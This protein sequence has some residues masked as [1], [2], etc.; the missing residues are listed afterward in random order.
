MINL[1]EVGATIDLNTKN[2]E[3][4]IKN[5]LGDAGKLDKAILGIESASKL[6]L[7]SIGAFTAGIVALGVSVG[8]I[9]LEYNKEIE[10]VTTDFEVM[11]GSVEDGVN[12][13]E[14]L[15][16]MASS[17]PFE[18]PQL[19]QN[20]K[21]LLAFNIASDDTGRILRQL[22]DISLG[23]AEKLD[24]LTR[25]YGKMNASQ[26]VSLED[27]NIMIDA[28]FNPLLLVAEKTGETMTELYDRISKGKVSVNEI[29]QAFD[30][31]TGVGGQFYQ[32][33]E[34]ASK[35][36]QGL[37]STLQDNSN[38][39]FGSLVEPISEVLK[40]D[41]L[42]ALIDGIAELQQYLEDNP[43]A[44]ED[45]AKGLKDLSTEGIEIVLDGVKWF[46]D[47][48][49]DLGT[50][51]I[52][53]ASNIG[54]VATSLKLIVGILSGNIVGAVIGGVGLLGSLVVK[55]GN[56]FNST[57]E[58]AEEFNKKIEFALENEKKFME[59]NNANL[60]TPYKQ[61]VID[62]YDKYFINT[63]KEKKVLK[64]TND[65]ESAINEKLAIKLYAKNQEKNEQLLEMQRMLELKKAKAKE[66]IQTA[67]LVEK[68]KELKEV[69]D[70][71]KE[72]PNIKLPTLQETE[73]KI[74]IP[75]VDALINNLFTDIPQIDLSYIF[76]DIENIADKTT[77]EQIEADKNAKRLQWEGQ[78]RW[79]EL[80]NFL[81]DKNEETAD[82]IVVGTKKQASAWDKYLDSLKIS[83][84]EVALSMA[85]SVESGFTDIIGGF[86][87]VGEA[88]IMGED[89]WKAFGDSALRSIGG[90]LKALGD[91]LTAM[92]VTK[93]LMGDLVSSGLALAGATTAYVASGALNAI[94]TPVKPVPETVEKPVVKESNN[95]ATSQ[96]VILEL[97][98][99]VLG[100]FIY[101]EN[102]RRT[103][104]I[105][106]NV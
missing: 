41:V 45:V 89:A 24:S 69:K 85:K 54:I 43:Q 51:L 9:G 70:L 88:L 50:K 21:T 94:A 93:L 80:Q 7:A 102:A 39:L 100:S 101:N 79:A 90:V 98:G 18:L 72:N 67:Q 15:K 91:Q 55:I 42:P 56:Y 6:A 19:A 40:T 31:A 35:T 86:S 17:T 34:K 61:N 64:E 26:K 25:A 22:G 68:M 104:Q 10:S 36:T 38:A 12:K 4:G 75:D 105:G 11:L 44:L 57:S 49:D 48:A 20:T 62:F 83:W 3:K 58:E 77:K 5:A 16:K 46:I 74:T 29:T 99:D 1:F 23:N 76:N 37:L 8:K 106:V 59:Y 71:L 32:G 92:S 60:D 97:D 84:E 52:D 96:P 82:N 73:F 78:Q 66:I 63:D 33:M 27:I 53:L 14:E 65:L 81:V 2:F 30:K 13:V 87:D 103:K 47:N 95:Y 28:G